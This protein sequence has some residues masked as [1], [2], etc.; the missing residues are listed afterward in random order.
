M[1]LSNLK[2]IIVLSGCP[3]S[4]KTA[5]LN[6]VCNRIS[7]SQKM[8][9]F[10]PNEQEHS[11]TSLGDQRFAAI[12]NGRKVAVCTAGDDATCVF[13]AFLYAEKVCA[14][15]VVM[16]LSVHKYGYKTAEVA[17]NE[18]VASQRL[19]SI[20]DRTVSTTKHKQPKPKGYVDA[21]KVRAIFHKI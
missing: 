19:R 20:V 17:F 15:A 9:A 1:N 3:D 21:T 8:T 5:I 4:G 6:E 10:N 7:S 13:K 16:A 11:R 14:D 18:I 12:Y 2:S